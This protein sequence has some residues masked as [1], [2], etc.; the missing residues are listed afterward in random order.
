MTPVFAETIKIAA[1]DDWIPYAK[2]D[3]TG[4]TNEIVR[5]AFKSVGIKVEYSIYP[6]SR[7]LHYL[8]S[9]E[10]V[11]GFN[12][13]YDEESQRKYILGKKKLFDAI[14][15][16]YE[17]ISKPLKCK[18]R[19][20]L[21]SREKIGVVRGYGY[22]NHFVRLLKEKRVVKEVTS[23]ESSNL[24]KLSRGR[25]D[26]TIIYKKTSKILIKKL[27]LAKKIKFA[28]VNEVTP[29][30]L[31]FS[32]YHKKAQYFSDKFDEGMR[33]IQLNGEYE[34]ILALY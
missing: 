26:S 9:G 33:K 25:I 22:G 11:A 20:A 32:R 17:N 34:K 10:Y 5:A 29:I 13:P 1:E 15:G 28:F 27:N 7:V 16:Y 6:Y 21:R 31:A 30:F 3:G 19:E 24:L 2:G 23:S 8:D 18:K 4:L 12:V 14:S